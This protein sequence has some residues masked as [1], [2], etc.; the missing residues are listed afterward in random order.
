MLGKPIVCA[1]ARSGL[2]YER[3]VIPGSDQCSYRLIIPTR[4]SF[5]PHRSI[6][7]KQPLAPFSKKTARGKIRIVALGVGCK[8]G[9]T[10]FA[11][12]DKILSIQIILNSLARNLPNVGKYVI[13]LVGRDGRLVAG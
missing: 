8:N 4:V 5:N 6:S 12:L 9:S 1:A 10:T 7:S 11:Q 2:L 13:I 3:P